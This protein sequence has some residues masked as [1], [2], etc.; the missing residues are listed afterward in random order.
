M[1]TQQDETKKLIGKKI[2]YHQGFEKYIKQYLSAFTMDKQEKYN[3]TTNENSKCL[4]YK[5][6]DWIDSLGVEKIRIRHYST[7]NDDVGIKEIQ[8]KGTQ[9]LTEKNISDIERSSPYNLNVKK[10]KIMLYYF[11]ECF[12]LTNG[13]LPVPDGETSPGAEKYLLKDYMNFTK[14]PNLTS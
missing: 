14:V 1:I 13:L 7:V 11:N 2:S 4:L 8:K 9:F 6:N 10:T 12:P 5:F 3:L